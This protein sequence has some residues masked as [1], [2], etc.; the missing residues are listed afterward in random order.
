MTVEQFLSRHFVDKNNY[1][2]MMRF[3]ERCIFEIKLCHFIC[4]DCISFRYY[5]IIVVDLI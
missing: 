4:N 2:K 3:R 5:D 1:Y